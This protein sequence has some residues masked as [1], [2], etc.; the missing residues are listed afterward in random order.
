MMR[1]VAQCWRVSHY[2]AALFVSHGPKLCQMRSECQLTYT[3]AH[4]CI[5]YAYICISV[6]IC[7]YIHIHT[8]IYI[9]IYI[10]IHIYV[11]TYV[12]IYMCV[13][14]HLHICIY[15]YIYTCVYIYM[16]IY[17]HIYIHR[18]IFMYIHID[19]WYVLWVATISRLLKL[20]GL[21]CRRALRKRTYSAKAVYNLKESTNH[22]HP[23]VFQAYPLHIYVCAHV[24]MYVH[25]Y[26]CWSFKNALTGPGSNV[27]SMVL[28]SICVSV[29]ISKMGGGVYL[30]ETNVTYR[31]QIVR[32]L[33]LCCVP[34]KR[35]GVHTKILSCWNPWVCEVCD[36]SH[37][38]LCAGST[39]YQTGRVCV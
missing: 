33:Y 27:R 10:Y 23:I 29:Y 3:Y 32:R 6:Y 4:V 24:H 22:S 30:R 35:C 12:Y 9:Y 20:I 8:C 37:Q 14:T 13:Y 15:V 5:L 16:C 26:L 38:L 36:T 25:I 7:V 11:Y 17:I 18:E 31:I 39:P 1:S 28:F 21:F 19:T 2:V 34:T